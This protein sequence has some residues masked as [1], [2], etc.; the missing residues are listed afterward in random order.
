MLEVL[1][2]VNITRITIWLFQSDVYQLDKV[3][4]KI[5]MK[6]KLGVIQLEL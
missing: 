4:T 3:E 5:D 6:I 1:N 2:H